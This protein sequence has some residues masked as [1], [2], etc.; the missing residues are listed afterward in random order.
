[1]RRHRA[2]TIIGDADKPGTM[3]FEYA[4]GQEFKDLLAEQAKHSEPKGAGRHLRKESPV[5]LFKDRDF[6][7]SLGRFT[8]IDIFTGNYDRLTQLYNPE[9]FKV[10]RLTKQLC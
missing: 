3:V 7:T 6:V 5:R 4:P 8:A 1:M 9:N 2:K 10:D